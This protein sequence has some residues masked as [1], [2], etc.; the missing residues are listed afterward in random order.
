MAERIPRINDDVLRRIVLSRPPPDRLIANLE[1]A[2]D[3][4]RYAIRRRADEM[5]PVLWETLK[6]VAAGYGNPRIAA[7]LGEELETIKSRVQR[8]L[9]YFDA[10]DR[11]ELVVRCY[12][13]GIM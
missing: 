12:R 13:E 6:L 7:E 5:T 10:R 11:L 9:G 4:P 3:V 2:R 8:L 1:L